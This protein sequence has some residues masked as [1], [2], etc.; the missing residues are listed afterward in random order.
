MA[1]ASMRVSSS[2][3]S[4]WTSPTSATIAMERVTRNLRTAVLQS[5]L[6]TTCTLPSCTE[7]AFLKGTPTACSSTRT[8]TTR[9]TPSARAASPTT[10]PAG[11][12]TETVQKPGLP[13]PRRRRLPLLRQPAPDARSAPRCWPPT[14]Q[15]TTRGVQLLHRGRPDQRHPARDGLA[16]HGGP[17]Q[18]GRQHRRLDQRP[19]RGRSRTSPAPR[20]CSASPCPTPTASSERMGP[21]MNRRLTALRDDSGAAL[22]MVIGLVARAR[23]AR[24]RRRSG[25]AIQT[26]KVA[27]NGQEWGGAQSAAM[28]GIEDYVARLNRNDNYG[29]IW[30]CTQQ[31]AQGSQPGRQHLRLDRG[32]HAGLAARGRH[33]P[34]PGPTF[35]YDVDSSM[36]DKN[37]TITVT[38][39]GSCGGGDAHR[40]RPR[41]GAAARPTSSTTP[42]SSTR[43][44]R[45]RPSTPRPRPSTSAAPR[46]RRRTSTG[47]ARRSPGTTGRTPAAS[48]SGS[49]AATRSTA[50]C[51]STT[52]PS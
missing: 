41:S 10:S 40:R 1:T 26:T 43:I 50:G 52:R 24:D 9:R 31:R 23:H 28:A 47:G 39:T 5:Q 37:G 45:T 14:W 27:Q 48:R 13:D 32:D 29:R 16:A 21:D 3:R 6:T 46:V 51:T 17:A 25:Y 19:A 33:R 11:V 7:S 15:A 49:P 36:L 20:W 8:S 44:P 12:L 35:H 38:S 42:T 2:S 4:A 22:I 34:R 30:D 18:V